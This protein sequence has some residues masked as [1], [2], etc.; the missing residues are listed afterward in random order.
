MIMFQ[1][2]A[3][4]DGVRSDV[5]CVSGVFSDLGDRLYSQ[6]QEISAD[7]DKAIATG[8][9]SSDDPDVLLADVIKKTVETFLDSYVLVLVDNSRGVGTFSQQPLFRV[10]SLFLTLNLELIPNPPF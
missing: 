8:A 3:P 5:D 6:Y 10:R 2:V 4:T 1:L 9:I 7:L